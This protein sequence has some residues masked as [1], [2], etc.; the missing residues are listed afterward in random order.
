[1]AE[2]LEQSMKD[3]EQFMEAESVEQFMDCL[4]DY[5]DEIT[6]IGNNYQDD[7]GKIV[8]SAHLWQNRIINPIAALLG[9]SEEQT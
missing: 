3:I 4:A 2:N 7:D 6:A 5:L 9:V 1:M 8:L